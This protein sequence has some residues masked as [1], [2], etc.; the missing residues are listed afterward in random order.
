MI[1]NK[2]VKSWIQ[3]MNELLSPEDI[4]WIDGSE[5][6]LKLLK[7]ISCETLE[8]IK[9]NQE[10]MP[11]CYLHRSNEND[12]CRV[13]D[14]TF[15]CCNNKIDAGFTNNWWEPSEAIDKLF[16][17]AKGSYRGKIMYV[18][19]FSMANPDS[20][21]HK[22]GIEITDSIYVALSMTIM[23]RVGKEISKKFGSSE[24]N[25]TRCLHCSCSCNENER[26]IC[27]FPEKNMIISVNSSYG[28]NAL[29]GKKCLALRL[30]SY[31]GKNE[32]W[33]AE[34][35]LTMGIKT[36]YNDEIKYVCASFPSGCG[37]TDLAMM[38]IS[39]EFEKMGYRIECVGDD[40]SWLKVGPDGRL[41]A[42]N[43]E[44]GVFGACAGINEKNNY[45][46]VEMSKKDT[47]FTNVILNEEN[48]TVW[49]EGLNNNPP[50]D[51]TDWLGNEWDANSGVVG[52]QK[53]SRFAAPLVN[54]PCLSSEYNNPN[55]V[56]ISAII[57]GVKRKSFTPLVI[58]SSDWDH[59]VFLGSIMSSETTVASSGKVGVLRNDPFGMLPFCGYN[60][61]DYLQH[62]INIG[63]IL[64]DKA[65]K[66]FGVNWF[67][68]NEKG[69]YIWKGFG[70]NIR[71]LD[72]ILKRCNNS[73]KVRSS[74]LGF[75]PNENDINID[76]LKISK[77]DLQ[78][79][80]N[81]DSES[82]KNEINRINEF[83][84]KFD[85]PVPIKLRDI[86]NSVS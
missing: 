4:V 59:G 57:L 60:M 61:S 15:I 48:Q 33:L 13:E 68:T 14:K 3:E 81:F 30:G 43:P 35:M 8:L 28:G 38:K 67:R 26:Y 23:S 77:K 56:P 19:P 72:W 79:I 46:I 44:N 83:Y 41:W 1:R 78:S 80:L 11:N 16:K 31:M 49:W 53:N 85:K 55:G 58:E 20:D 50:S 73:L 9:L 52:A 40:I 6:Q 51:A 5:A 34:H 47:I 69:E 75:L 32:G 54:C 65:P 74:P 76:G 66:I 84:S 2:Y 29:L 7:N 63:S 37:K 42:V 39:D 70:E 17:I 27:H 22:L 21:F 82:L 18:V 25:W 62:W 10:I 45:N 36:P 71:V 12:V 64:G 24:N 86:L